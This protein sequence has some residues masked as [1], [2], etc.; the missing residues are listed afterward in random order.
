M[1][2]QSMSAS[3]RCALAMVAMSADSVP[4]LAQSMLAF[5]M[6][7]VVNCAVAMEAIRGIERIRGH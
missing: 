5:S 4:M 7:A 1:S 3:V 6:L 2:A